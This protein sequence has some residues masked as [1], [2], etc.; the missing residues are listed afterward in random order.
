MADLVKQFKGL[1]PLYNDNSRYIK[2]LDSIFIYTGGT[3]VSNITTR[4]YDSSGNLIWSVNH[5]DTVFGIAVDKNGNVYTGGDRA[6]HLTTRKYD[7]SGNLI[8][9]VNH[10]FTVRSVA[11]SPPQTAPF[12]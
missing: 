1:Y 5:G 9:S 7:S 8:W 4:K 10:G 12:I 2:Q 6:S 11:V 3:I